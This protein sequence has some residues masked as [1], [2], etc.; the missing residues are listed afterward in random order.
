MEIYKITEATSRKRGKMTDWHKKQVL[1]A[2]RLVDF[3][4]AHP[5]GV[6]RRDIESAGLSTWQIDR[7]MGLKLVVGTQIKEPERGLRCY[8]WLWKPAESEG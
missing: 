2:K 5:E 1:A 3:I 7:L 6:T 4:R 8:H